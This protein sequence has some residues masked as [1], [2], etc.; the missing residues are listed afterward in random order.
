[1]C[2]CERSEA[3]SRSPIAEIAASRALLAMTEPVNAGC[4]TRV[5]CAR[6][7]TPCH[8]FITLSLRAK[9]SNLVV[10]NR[11]DCRVAR[12]PRNDRA[13]QRTLNETS[14][15]RSRPHA[16]PRPYHRVIASEAKQ[17]QC[18]QPRRLP[19]R[20]APRNDGAC[21]RTLNETSSVRSRSHAMPR[22]YHGV[23]ASEAT[24]SFA[25]ERSEA[26]SR[27]PIAEIA[28]SLA[29]LAMTES[30]SAG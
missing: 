18:H 30:V 25:I 27:S 7:P 23:I 9:R 17:S 12:A 14:S 24:Q 2:H 16:M 29:L 13:C 4:T 26:I 3:I 15:V 11:G 19:R 5:R 1:M 6:G 22:L 8:A 20:C 28:A 10:T 21:Q